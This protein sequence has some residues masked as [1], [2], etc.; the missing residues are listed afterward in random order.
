LRCP[1]A[2]TTRT[3]LRVVDAPGVHAEA[4]AK[5]FLNLVPQGTATATWV[6]TSPQ[7]VYRAEFVRRLVPLPPR[8]LGVT[9][10]EVREGTL[11]VAG[12]WE[13]HIP[14]GGDAT[15]R[16]RVANWQGPLNLDGPGVTAVK[17]A[18][19]QWQ[20]PVAAGAPRRFQL[21][22]TGSQPWP[23]GTVADLPK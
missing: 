2:A 9:T 20:V 23:T 10:V 18:G 17:G 22:L 5:T 3:V 7:G 19:Q 11:H 12:S 13:V 21:K 8:L 6:C 16:V 14:H 1:D 15:F 4:D